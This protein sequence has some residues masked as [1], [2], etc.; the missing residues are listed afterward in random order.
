MSPSCPACVSPQRAPRTRW[1]V[2]RTAKRRRG[3]PPAAVRLLSG[4]RA[5][6]I[7]AGRPKQL[8]SRTEKNERSGRVRAL[9]A[10]WPWAGDSAVGLIETLEGF[11]DKRSPKMGGGWQK[12]WWV[13]DCA[14]KTFSYFKAKD[15]HTMFTELDDDGSGES[16]SWPC[17]F[18]LLLWLTQCLSVRPSRLP[19]RR[20]FFQAHKA[21]GEEAV[22]HR[23]CLVRSAAFAAAKSLPFPCGAAGPRK[24]WC[25]RWPRSTPTATAR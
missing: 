8:P 23:L 1:H 20:R 16:L 24:R 21:A 14:A 6:I 11:L 22:R 25:R 12:R 5:P 18:P 4:S 2:P 17:V 15:A 7:V 3:T 10:R 9:S 19:R 13:L